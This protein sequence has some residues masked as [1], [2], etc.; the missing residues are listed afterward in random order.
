MT[1]FLKCLKCKVSEHSEKDLREHYLRYHKFVACEKCW[2]SM[3]KITNVADVGMSGNKWDGITRYQ[4]IDE[5]CE[6]YEK[7]IEIPAGK[8]GSI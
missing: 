1:K 6:K 4:C 8:L 2:Q 5:D 3:K 7:F